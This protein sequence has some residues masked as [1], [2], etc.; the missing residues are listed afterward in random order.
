MEVEG[1][2]LLPLG[3]APLFL[4]SKVF[5]FWAAFVAEG[6]HGGDDVG[7]GDVLGHVLGVVVEAAGA[8]DDGLVVLFCPLC[9]KHPAFIENHLYDLMYG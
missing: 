7:V 6:G 1:A 8:D 4:K 9:L 3:T 2:V 5:Y